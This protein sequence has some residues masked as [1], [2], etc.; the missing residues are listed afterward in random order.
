M[1]MVCVRLCVVA[2]T[3]IFAACG[4][5]GAESGFA[6]RPITNNAFAETGYTLHRD[7][8]TVGLGR[9]EYGIGEHVQ[10][11]TNLL[12]WAFQVYNADLKVAFTKSEERAYAVGVAVYDLSLADRITDEEGD[13]MALMPYLAGSWRLSSGTLMHAY[14]RYAYLKAEDDDNVDDPEPDE[15]SSGTGVYLGLEHSRTDRTK[16]L[17]DLGYDATYDGVRAGAAVLFGWS[18]F[19][20]KLGLS[21]FAAGDGFFFPIIGLWWRFQ[22]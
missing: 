1:C 10:L 22:A 18:S 21:Y 13:Y 2:A 5:E 20:L 17:A 7:E 4:V 12:L 3:I 6:G 8:F 15:I 19:R 9:I 11:G 14:G 16:F